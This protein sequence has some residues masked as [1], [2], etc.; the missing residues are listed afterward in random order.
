MS[1]RYSSIILA[2]ASLVF[3]SSCSEAI[4]SESASSGELSRV[5]LTASVASESEVADG[6]TR[7]LDD[8][9]LPDEVVSAKIKDFWLLEYDE[10]GNLLGNPVYVENETA[11]ETVRKFVNL[12]VPEADGTK[13]KC[14][15]IANT[16][17]NSAADL[18]TNAATLAQLK[19]YGKAVTDF[20]SLYNPSATADYP[21]GCLYMN[22]MVADISRTTSSL[23]FKL[24]R[25][26]AK[27]TVTL[28]NS[29]NSNVKLTS[30]QVRNVP[31][32]L[33]YAD[34]L[35]DADY[36]GSTLCPANG[37]C[38]Y[39]D[40]PID[41][42]CMDG[43]E[44]QL[45]FTYYLPRNQRGTTAN[46]APASKN[47]NAPSNATF[48]EIY[49]I[50]MSDGSMLRYRLYPGSNTYN[51]F[52]ITPNC[53]Y[54]MP[55]TIQS[56]HDVAADSRVESFESANCYIV[57][58]KLT[59]KINYVPVNRV[60]QFWEHYNTANEI[61]GN[62]EWVAEIIWDD[63]SQSTSPSDLIEFCD[64]KGNVSTSFTGKGIMPISFKTKGKE[65][66]VLI[67]VRK[68]GSK[69]YLWSWHLWITS[70]DPEAEWATYPRNE[71]KDIYMDRNLGALTDDMSD[72]ENTYGL[73]YQFGRKDPIPRT[74]IA[75][76]DCQVY[77]KEPQPYVN[78]VYKPNWFV[79]TGS[80]S[81]HNWAT[82]CVVENR[83]WNNPEWNVS[84]AKS[85]FDPS[86][87]GWHVP[88][89]AELSDLD[90]ATHIDNADWKY[91]YLSEDTNKKFGLPYTG[92]HSYN[93]IDGSE[94]DKS[95]NNGEGLHYVGSR[96]YLWSGTPDG[97]N[98]SNANYLCIF[99]GE[100]VRWS[101]A[102]KAYGLSVRCVRDKK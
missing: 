96:T 71:T 70:Y 29:A 83:E 30:V 22:S 72:L 28:A 34:V 87:S 36:S 74:S 99:R 44:S 79:Y 93:S 8:S 17:D 3:F 50:N 46:T 76:Y 10:N 61:T 33:V 68:P 81:T 100:Q 84:K 69:D 86:P 66:N 63:K 24:H 2:L 51:D 11:T 25:N 95:N 16:H 49:G 73:Y 26:V 31:S 47:T 23:E 94:E 98:S 77:F 55:L 13:Y 64:E 90:K 75:G 43:G 27:L 40:L 58:P 91:T 14:V 53:H 19:E 54:T 21:D 52:N 57:N 65:G 56:P 7:A 9:K 41:N 48:V 88:T 62:D 32:R 67:G 39:V 4:F 38:Q 78:S 59:K 1:Y 37:E 42:I 45:S 6:A 18:K 102:A 60:N 101:D 82:D 92:G 89:E 20:N 15:L 12:A 97:E 5:M 35:H 85:F 80:E